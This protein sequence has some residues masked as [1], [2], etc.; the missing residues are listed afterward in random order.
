MHYHGEVDGLWQWVEET[1][2]QADVLVLSTDSLIYGGLVDSRKHHTPL[3]ILESRVARIRKLKEV[4]KHRPIYAFGTIMRSPRASGG[5][6]EPDYYSAYGPS[7]FRIAA[8]QDKQDR[9]G[10]TN[11]DRAELFSLISNVPVD[12]LQDWFHRRYVNMVINKELID[13]VR[14]HTFTYFALGHDDTS[15]LSQS[16]LEARYLKN[17]SEHISPKEYGSFPGADQ[18]GLLLIARA[19]VDQYQE[20]PTF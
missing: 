11:E 20:R 6:V 19:R 15:S 13:L 7:I 2:P 3:S 9:T 18:L 16:A 8:L 12:F 5:G 17:Y 14:N 4:A 1:A 10:L